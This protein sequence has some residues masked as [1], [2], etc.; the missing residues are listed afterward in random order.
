RPAP[1]RAA[2]GKAIAPPERAEPAFSTLPSPDRR[3]ALLVAYEGTEGPSFVRFLYEGAGEPGP[4]R[5]L[6]GALPVAAFAA[7]EPLLATAGAAGLCVG[8]LDETRGPAHC[9]PQAA[10]AIVRMENGLAPIEQ[11]LASVE[12]AGAAT[13]ARPAAPAKKKGART[14]KR[15][16]ARA[17]RGAA[18]GEPRPPPAS[19]A[20][21]VSIWLRR[22]GPMGEPQGEPQD[23]GL[24]FV[25]PLAG[26]ALNQAVAAGSG[27]EL[28][29]Y[30]QAEAARAPGAG[31]GRAVPR[32]RLVA[33]RLDAAGRY[34][35]ASRRVL[36]EG[37]KGWGY[38][39]GHV[40]PRLFAAAGDAVFV[41]R[42]LPSGAA[43]GGC[44]ARPLAGNPAELRPPVAVC[45]V[46]PFRLASPAPISAAELA[47]LDAVS[48]LGPVLSEG[49]PPGEAERVAWVGERGYFLQ[50][51]KLR[52][53]GRAGTGVR[54]EPHPFVAERSRIFWGV[55]GPEGEGLAATSGGLVELG[56]GASLRRHELPEPG[57]A[58]WLEPEARPQV[59]H[60]GASWWAIRPARGEGRRG[61]DVV[62][63][64]P[65]PA[66]P[67]PLAALAY[68]DSSALVGGARR[69]L[70]VVRG[71][72]LGV[73]RLG[74]DGTTELLGSHR[75]DLP[76]GFSAVSRAGGGALLAGIGR[77]GYPVTLALGDDGRL[78]GT[79]RGPQAVA[80]GPSRVWLVP[81]AGGGALLA[82]RGWRHAIWIDDDGRVLATRPWPRER[83]RSACLDGEPAPL[84]LPGPEP[85]SMVRPAALGEGGSCVVGLP[86]WGKE[87]SLFWLGSR[88]DGLDSRAVL[89]VLRLPETT[90]VP[91]PAAASG[92]AEP[93]AAP[94][95]TPGGD[96]RCPPDM[97]LVAGRYCVD[98]FE[99]RLHDAATGLALSADY[100]ASPDM[101]RHAW[102]E[103]TTGRWRVGDL[104]ARA[105]PLPLLPAWQ[106]SAALRPVARS[107]LGVVPSG[108]VS[109]L[110]AEQACTSAGKRLCTV[111]EF[112]TA[113]RGEKGT[114]FPYGAD[115]EPGAC[116][117]FRPEHPAAILHGNASL[118]HLDPRL[119]RVRAGEGPL[120][121][122]A[123]ATARC[124]SRWGDDEIYDLVGNLDE[125]LDEP[126]G[127]FAGG[128]YARA[129]RQGCEALI[130]AHP[131]RYL[132][133]STGVRC[134]RDAKPP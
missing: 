105:L 95:R 117:V 72:R 114:L 134:C 113:C 12:R 80:P 19:A 17:K 107:E 88:M 123:G 83:A 77:D 62:R 125:W 89:G 92:S 25:P 86:V 128:F 44:E 28:L 52:S 101:A 8:P 68:P 33:G 7:P 103:W 108:Y 6:R 5:V 30:E 53:F 26:M 45:A 85:G 76:L 58:W 78:A 112:V 37:E 57:A 98:R 111:E 1:V 43:A 21:G 127:A 48:G 39:E 94:A 50:G 3:S 15:R 104:A 93:A 118:G 81:R 119:N 102:Q 2:L 49:Q 38:I 82:D 23:T 40:E 84:V 9:R 126:G 14:G 74:E 70:F 97:V 61:G 63:L 13:P 121:R 4:V 34:D 87:G 11:R 132:D 79:H 116:N 91:A 22:L 27:V 67:S 31:R 122:P 56:A 106:L 20:L 41:G 66:E 71:A 73:Y 36:L 69:G 47:A 51:G 131:R 46:D 99:A 54:D 65:S 35:P 32:A 129:T 59:A 75:A 133:Y 109:G 96:G 42:V 90:P 110:V 16:P 10:Q 120:L 115:Y 60:I 55:L 130:T 64:L 29:W 18:T 100:A 24:R 124:A